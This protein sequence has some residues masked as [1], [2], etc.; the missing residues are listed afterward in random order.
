[1]TEQVVDAEVVE[2]TTV[3]EPDAPQPEVQSTALE[4]RP[5]SREVL[6]P[7]DTEQVVQGM[8]AY[9][10]LLPKLLDESDYQDAGFDKKTGKKRKFV[11]KSGWRKIAR[12]FNLSTQLISVEIQR[13]A[14]GAPIKAQSIVRAIAPN[15]Q[16]SDGDGYCSVDEKRFREQ[17]AD[18][19]KTENDLRAT[20]TTRAK[21]RAISDLVGM[22]EAS[23]EEVDAGAS[24]SEPRATD[25][26]IAVLGKAMNWLLPNAAAVAAT[27]DAIKEQCGGE[28]TGPVANALIVAI[29]A[30]KDSE[31]QVVATEQDKAAEQ[32]DTSSPDPVPAEV[33]DDLPAAD[34]A[35]L[36]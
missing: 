2:E 21:N 5:A 19:A 1:M 20:A 4:V 7:L 18:K 23:A 28:I 16:I 3:T 11:K 30:R 26:Q 6:M 17:P 13:D 9:Q 8:K 24:A 29:K 22:G 31:G 35:G 36:S 32:P 10:D 27:W 25:K 14:D 15:G 34:E 33:E 12:A